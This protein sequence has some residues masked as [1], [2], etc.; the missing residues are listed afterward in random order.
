MDA[1]YLPVAEDP[2]R[3]EKIYS[4]CKTIRS[5][6]CRSSSHSR[7]VPYTCQGFLCRIFVV[8]VIFLPQVFADVA[9][10]VNPIKSVHATTSCVCNRIIVIPTFLSHVNFVLPMCDFLQAFL[11]LWLTS[12]RN[13]SN[14]KYFVA[15][16]KFN[17]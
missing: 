4:G 5:V 15:R 6:L 12:E 8:L 9:L 14:Q 10:V 17:Y 11:Y 16:T 2:P 3:I 7:D 13:V 1:K